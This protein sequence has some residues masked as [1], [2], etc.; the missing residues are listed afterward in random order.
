V[1]GGGGIMCRCVWKIIPWKVVMTKA[2]RDLTKSQR[3]K[4]KRN[5]M[6]YIR[7]GSWK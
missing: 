2:N 4:L 3:K 1:Y 5:Y 7:V 6:D